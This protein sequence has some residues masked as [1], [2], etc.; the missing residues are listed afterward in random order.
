MEKWMKNDCPQVDCLNS[1]A[2]SNEGSSRLKKSEKNV[3]Q[4]EVFAEQFPVFP[5]I[6]LSFEN[7][8]ASQCCFSRIKP[9]EILMRHCREGRVECE[10]GQEYLYQAAR[11]LCIKRVSAADTDRYFPNGRYCGISIVIDTAQARSSIFQIFSINLKK[12]EIRLDD[13]HGFVIMRE[14]QELQHVFCEMAAAPCGQRAGYLRIK[15][16]ELLYL[17]DRVFCDNENRKKFS[18]K[19]IEAAKKLERCLTGHPEEV[20]D[21]KALS[22]K[23]RMPVTEIKN[24]FYGVY[25]VPVHSFIRN[26]RMQKAAE[27][28]RTTDYEV[29]AIARMVGYSS[30]NK[31]AHT[32]CS[33]TRLSPEECRSGRKRLKN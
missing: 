17:L 18:W 14:N 3:A 13:A 15:V 25:G 21:L 11:D 32:F 28:L 12:L 8:R 6:L 29:S 22:L 4:H 7:I 31:F 24:I 33:V 1:A 5:G 27:L 30:T 20:S 10:T 23:L 26:Y 19:Q 16:L 9:G 2:L